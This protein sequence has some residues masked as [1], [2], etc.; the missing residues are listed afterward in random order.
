MIER[1]VVLMM[2]VGLCASMSQAGITVTD[3]V[4]PPDPATWTTLIDVYIGETGAGSVIVDA[5]SDVVSYQSYLGF[6]SGSTG[7][8]TVRGVGSTW[9]NSDY[10]L[11]GCYGDGTLDITN[12]GAVSDWQGYIGY[13]SGSTGA[14]TVSGTGATWINFSGVA[15][16]W[17]GG[18]TLDITNGGAVSSPIAFISS[19]S[20]STGAV[21]VSGVGSTWTNSLLTIGR[22]GDSTLNI[23]DGGLVSVGD[24]LAGF[25]D[26]LSV[27]LRIDSSDDGVSFI[28]MATGGKLALEG[29]ADN[30]LLDFLEL[31][32]GTDDIRYW[33]GSTWADITGATEN[34]DYTLSYLTEGDLT[35]YTMLTVPEPVTMIVMALGGLAVLRRRS[36]QAKT[37]LRRRR[38]Q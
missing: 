23:D 2:S 33:N 15:V 12:G 7:A 1:I 17:L 19:L 21:T 11:V 27:G 8:V 29:E 37:I 34:V 31:I 30:S 36:R 4:I 16:G 24:H 32:D 20:G 28:T 22:S 18:G 26:N 14:V 5:D 35:G 13:L 6:N 9:T 25:P 10:L 38:K 3:D